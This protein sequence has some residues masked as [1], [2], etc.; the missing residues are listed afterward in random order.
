MLGSKFI[1]AIKRG[2]LSLDIDFQV[3]YDTNWTSL[4]HPNEVSS[5]RL[6][7]ARIGPG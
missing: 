2:H 7:S 1:V 4:I 5:V 6:A 3:L